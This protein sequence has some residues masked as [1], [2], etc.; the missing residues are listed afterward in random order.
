MRTGWKNRPG[1]AYDEE[2]LETL[3]AEDMQEISE[4]VNNPSGEEQSPWNRDIHTNGYNIYRGDDPAFLS[5]DPNNGFLYDYSGQALMVDWNGGR[6]CDPINDFDIVSWLV[7]MLNTNFDGSNSVDW[8]NRIL[9]ASDGMSQGLNYSLP[10]ALSGADA[11]IP[12]D[13]SIFLGWDAGDLASMAFNSV[14]LGFYAGNFAVNAWG[15]VFLGD[16]AGAFSDK[17]ALSIFL[18]NTA[19]LGA[20]KANNSIFM[21]DMAGFFDPVINTF[22]VITEI[23]TTPDTPG[24]GYTQGDILTIVTGSRDALV[25]VDSVDENGGVLSVHLL[26]GGAFYYPEAFVPV[27]GGTGND[28]CTIE[29]TQVSEG[30]TSIAIGRYSGTGGYSDSIAIGHGV[31]NSAEKQA[32]IGNVLFLDETYNSDTQDATPQTA[33]IL[34]VGGVFQL[35]NFAAFTGTPAEGMMAYDFTNGYPVY[36]DGNDWVQ[37]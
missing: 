28:D 1:V 34:S 22:G 16:G 29:I 18:G 3:Y 11:G 24:T 13:G 21:G 12:V 6:L 31:I 8:E 15:S 35:P 20:S 25:E 26:E 36:Y 5:I 4:A 37:I 7:G 9:Y 23:N 14:F 10:G 30:G 19:G 17:A 2:D 32:N 27:S 33:G